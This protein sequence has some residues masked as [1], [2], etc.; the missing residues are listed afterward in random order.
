MGRYPHESGDCLVL[1]PE[2]F[3]SLDREVICWQ[4]VNYV[5]QSDGQTQASSK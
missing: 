2:I 3:V 5:R 1:G 4:G